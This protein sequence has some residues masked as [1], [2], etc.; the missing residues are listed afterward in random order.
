MKHTFLKHALWAALFAAGAALAQDAAISGADFTHG[1]ADAKLAAIGGKAAADGQTVVVTAPTYWQAKAAAKIRAGAHGKP[2]AIRFSNGFYENVLVRTEAAAPAEAAARPEARPVVKQESKP[3]PRL[4]AKAEPKARA[5][6]KMARVEPKAA[7]S[8]EPKQQEQEP[9]AAPV[10]VAAPAPQPP[11]PAQVVAPAPMQAPVQQ[12]PASEAPQ[13]APQ[14]ASDLVAVPQVSRQP[15][16]VPIPTAAINTT[17]V[18]PAV[19]AAP[20]SHSD[21]SVRQRMLASLNDARPAM[22]S[23]SEGQLQSGDQVYADG[24]TLAVVR[25]EGLHR[26][27]YW[28]QGPVDLQRIQFM[29]QGSGHYQV[30][31]PID[32]KAPAVHRKAGNAR[33]V[34][35]ASIPADGSAARTRLE[36]QYNNGQPILGSLTAA[37]LQPEDRLLVDGEAIVVARREGNSMARYWLS[38]SIDLGQ[39]GLQKLDGNVYRVTG[40]SLH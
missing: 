37:R 17:S 22:G 3:Q 23:L 10:A 38:G 15:V 25:L 39:T 11:A 16:V 14:V 9:A 8:T 35:A 40:N 24:D 36:Q 27:L 30:T 19:P 4:A 33:Q 31:G 20:S 32:P 2:V 7:I 28:L 34:F 6:A 5:E 21:V 18:Q 1:K 12:A 13:A 29:P 26:S